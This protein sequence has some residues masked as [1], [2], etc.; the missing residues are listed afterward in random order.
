MTRP[1]PEDKEEKAGPNAVVRAILRLIDRAIH[2]LNKLQAK[3]GGTDDEAGRRRPPDVAPE[4]DQPARKPSL[5]RRL[6]VWV[7]LLIVGA[8]VGGYSVYRELAEKLQAH[9]SV[10]EQLQDELKAA[11][12]EEARNLKLLDKFQQENAGYRLESRNAQREAEEATRRADA[13]EKQLEEL[14]RAAPAT[15]SSAGTGRTRSSASPP[16]K[17]GTC[18]AGSAEDLA[19]CI[20]QFNR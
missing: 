8:G 3:L 2:A 7:L 13:A 17:T 4:E 1:A 9:S 15:Q 18:S 20:E 6:A 10:V 16:R 12:K 5:L 11:Q 19:N 14:K